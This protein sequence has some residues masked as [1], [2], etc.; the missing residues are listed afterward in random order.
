MLQNKTDMKWTE[1]HAELIKKILE[2]IKKSPILAYP[3]PAHEFILETDASDRAIGAVLKQKEKM[4]DSIAKF[5]TTK[6]RYTSVEKEALGILKSIEFLKPY[7]I[8]YK[9]VIYTDNKNL[10]HENDLSKRIQRWKMLLEEYEY[11]LRHI[12]EKNVIADTI[13]RLSMLKLNTSPC[14]WKI[15]EK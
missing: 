10:L 4:S 7:V 13:S 12:E 8:G 14:Y 9:I 15:L 11:E 3:D 2:V 1:K 5:T 6:Q